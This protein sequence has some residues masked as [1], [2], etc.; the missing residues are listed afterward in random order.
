M[1]IQKF[2]G[3][4]GLARYI[5]VSEARVGQID[6][7]PDALVDGRPA[8]SPETAARLKLEREAR[9]AKRQAGAGKKPRARA[10]AQP[11]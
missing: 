3:R 1:A 2:F 10:E 8:W 5:G 9:L 7:A 6:P 4:G 11:A